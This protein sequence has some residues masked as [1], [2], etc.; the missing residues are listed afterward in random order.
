[1]FSKKF[2]LQKVQHKKRPYLQCNENV[3]LN[4]VITGVFLPVKKENRSLSTGVRLEEQMY[5]TDL[6]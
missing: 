5:R 6:P 3:H 4:H 1:M 2:N